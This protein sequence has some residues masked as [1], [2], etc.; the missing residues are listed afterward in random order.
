MRVADIVRKQQRLTDFII[1][2]RIDD[3]PFGEI[4]I[5]LARLNATEFSNGWAGG[6]RQLVEKLEGDGVPHDA[7]FNH[8]AV[9]QW[10]D[11]TFNV[12]DGLRKRGERHLSNWFSVALPPDVWLHTP[13]GLSNE[14]PVWAF[15]TRI[16]NGIL[17]FAPPTDLESGLGTLRI[18]SSLRMPTTRFLSEGSRDAETQQPR[19]RYGVAGEILGNSSELRVGW[20]HTAWRVVA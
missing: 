7:R 19:C 14:D 5:E 12:E 2:L 4:N 6:L 18:D 8:S 15:P 1:P 17:T 16:R 10:W 11:N 3:L 9:G 13:F 20:V